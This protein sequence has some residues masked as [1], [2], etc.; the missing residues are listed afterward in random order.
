MQPVF[1][2]PCLACRRHVRWNGQPLFTDCSCVNH[3]RGVTIVVLAAG[4]SAAALALLWR[5][6]PQSSIM[7]TKEASYHR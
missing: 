7:L 6:K 1:A 3:G 5:R 4:V 2:S